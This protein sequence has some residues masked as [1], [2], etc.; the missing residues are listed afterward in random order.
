MSRASLS[1]ALAEFTRARDE[2]AGLIVQLK[3]ARGSKADFRAIGRE[4]DKIDL[5][6]LQLLSHIEARKDSRP[7]KTRAPRQP[8]G[9]RAI[10]ERLVGARELLV[11]GFW[12]RYP[13]SDQR[14]HPKKYKQI[15]REM[16]SGYTAFD[17]LQSDYL[18]FTYAQRRRLQ[19]RVSYGVNQETQKIFSA[20]DIDKYG[21]VLNLSLDREEALLGLRGLLVRAGVVNTPTRPRKGKKSSR[22]KMKSPESDSQASGRADYDAEKEV[23]VPIGIEWWLV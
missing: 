2:I 19:L 18:G 23:A 21:L 5:A 11:R 7:K 16:R 8:Q 9:P 13:K 15:P 4:L 6:E 3:K 20:K 12:D 14:R 10:V 22:R 1:R 17:L